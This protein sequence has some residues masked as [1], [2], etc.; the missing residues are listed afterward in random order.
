MKPNLGTALVRSEAMHRAADPKA[1]VMTKGNDYSGAKTYQRG[2][3]QRVVNAYEISW[4]FTG[5]G[6]VVRGLVE[7]AGAIGAQRSK[8][9]GS[10]DPLRPPI[11]E[12][13]SDRDNGDHPIGIL[14]EDGSLVRPVPILWA[15][16]RGLTGWISSIER[17]A[18]PYR[19]A[20]VT[21]L[22]L[23][24]APVAWPASHTA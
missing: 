2:T 23:R 5:D 11:I 10:L 9:Y 22:G 21:R 6:D 18:I 16:R 7:G 13:L 17:Y 12:E 19:P 1:Q 14:D 3:L 20:E 24:K 8:G 15:H 4:L